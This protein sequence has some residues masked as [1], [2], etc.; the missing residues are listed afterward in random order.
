MSL[1]KWYV[2]L[3]KYYWTN[4]QIEGKQIVTIEIATGGIDYSGADGLHLDQNFERALGLSTDYYDPRKAVEAVVAAMPKL[5]E[6]FPKYEFEMTWVGLGMG[7]EGE[8]CTEE[9]LKA[10]ADKAYEKLEKCSQCA[11]VLNPDEVW[12]CEVCGDEFKFCREYCLDKHYEYEHIPNCPK[13]EKKL[14]WD[15]AG[16]FWYCPVYSC[17]YTEKEV[18][19]DD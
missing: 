6:K 10:R 4:Y 16:R 12:T 14:V 11:E 5:Q 9:Y 13:C 2:G 3:Q 17:D 15:E 19:S 18:N 8:G 1:P 7:E